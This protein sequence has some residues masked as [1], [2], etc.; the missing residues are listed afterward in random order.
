MEAGVLVLTECPSKLRR[1]THPHRNM[2][3]CNGSDV[4]E[5]GWDGGAFSLHLQGFWCYVCREYAVW[6]FL[7]NLRLGS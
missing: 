6:P 2:D 4:G 1:R 5:N 7:D 3:P